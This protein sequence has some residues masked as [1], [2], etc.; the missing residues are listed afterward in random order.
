MVQSMSQRL[1]RFGVYR[2]RPP[3]SNDTSRPAKSW[4]AR[5]ALLRD[6][7]FCRMW[8]VG[9]IYGTVRW[10]EVLAVAVFV[11]ELTDSPFMFP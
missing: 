1:N 3:D 6:P 7:N 4:R 5:L 8:A 9:L 10:L 2:N 11:F